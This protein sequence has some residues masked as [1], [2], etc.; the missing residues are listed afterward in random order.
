MHLSELFPCE[1][2]KLHTA[3][4]MLFMYEVDEPWLWCSVIVMFC[5]MV[6]STTDLFLV[7]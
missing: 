3:A 1:Q 7:Y 4:S 5:I 6:F 2:V